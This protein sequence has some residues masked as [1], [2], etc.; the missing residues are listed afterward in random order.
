M[1]DGSP[2]TAADAQMDVQVPVPDWDAEAREQ[3]WRTYLAVREHDAEAAALLYASITAYDDAQ[4]RAGGEPGA[5]TGGVARRLGSDSTREPFDP[6]RMFSQLARYYHWTDETMRKMPWKRLLAYHREAVLAQEDEDERF[7][8]H[9][10]RT[11]G[12]GGGAGAGASA[13]G[14]DAAGVLRDVAVT[15]RPYLGPTVPLA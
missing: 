12:D 5:A 3:A 14:V 1:V 2:A 11:N 10:A 8:D 7:R 13:S 9:M 15:P 6:A 4:Q